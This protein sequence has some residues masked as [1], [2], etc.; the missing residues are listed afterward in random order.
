MFRLGIRKRLILGNWILGWFDEFNN[1][2]SKVLEG[3]PIDP[4]DFHFLRMFYRIRFQK[5]S[6]SDDGDE[7]KNLAAWQKPETLYILFDAIWKNALIADLRFF[8]FLRYL[9][10]KGRILEYG[11]N[12]SPVVS[13]LIRFLPH[14]KY[15]LVVA[16]ILQINFIFSIFKFGKFKNVKPLLL[17]PL[18]NKISPDD[19]Y[20]AIICTEV[21]EHTPNPLEIIK[22]FHGSLNKKGIL[23]FDYIKS[24]GDGLDSK[25]SVKQRTICLEYI[26]DNF[27][28]LKGKINK[29]SNVGMV[30]ATPK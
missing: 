21:L 5:L 12:I 28:I 9:P 4:F 14:R 20:D 23:V 26:E 11:C 24:D 13:G 17:T 18:H 1:F 10:K 19:K 6:H 22:S 30:V 2:W 27:R 7:E 3:R 8:P 29:S 15:E 16:D 25:N